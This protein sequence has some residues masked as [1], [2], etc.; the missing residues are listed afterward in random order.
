LPSGRLFLEQ[1]SL[2]WNLVVME[3]WTE[4]EGRTIDGI[5]PL[6]KLLRP[7]GRSAFFLTSNGSGVPRVI[8]LIE[9]HFDEDDILA[10]WRGVAALNHPNILKLE[11]FGQVA[12]D[13]AP[14]LYAVMEPV[15][16]NLG[17]VLIEHRLG[18]PDARQLAVSVVSALDSLHSHGFIHEHVEPA[19]VF[20]VG[21]V[22]KLR[23]D[24]IREAPEGDEGFELKKRDVYDFS[25]LLLRGLTQQTTLEAAA[26]DLPLS[27]PFDQIVRNGMSGKWGVAEI[28]TA[29]ATETASPVVSESRAN[30]GTSTASFNGA[31]P[32]LVSVVESPA[33]NRVRVGVDRGVDGERSEVKLGT[34]LMVGLAA[35]LVLG[36][37]WHFLSD[38]RADSAV[39]QPATATQVP[40]PT[41]SGKAPT[42]PSAASSSSTGRKQQATEA[43]NQWRVIAYTYN[44]EDQA[45]HKVTVVAQ[46]HPELHPEVFSPT[47]NAPYLV[48]IGGPMSRDEAFALAQKARSEGLPGDTYAQ[49]Y[50]APDTDRSGRK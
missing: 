17:D 35:V 50:G 1:I 8:R 48:A 36:L 5:F 13:D 2:D 40:A 12:L 38:R 28:T 42:P 19:N 47:G 31:L 14:L 20:A 15:D 29:L 25:V 33:A 9:P 27:A 41:S 22:V 37:G 16:A 10:R 45:Q 44:H 46:A 49:N 34:K 18:L 43:R 3:L 4:Y 11:E 30:A 39:S 26:S 6:T 24:C 21:E 7:E 23:S 32:K